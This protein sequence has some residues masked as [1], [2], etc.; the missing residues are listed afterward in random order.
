MAAASTAPHDPQPEAEVPW[1]SAFPAPR[2][3]S[4]LSISRFE[5]LQL[6]KNVDE[7]GKD[8]VLVDLRRMDHEVKSTLLCKSLL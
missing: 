7:P 6:V 3:Q 4:P 8:F 1:H 2:K 5:V